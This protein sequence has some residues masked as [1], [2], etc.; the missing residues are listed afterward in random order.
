MDLRVKDGVKKRKPSCNEG[1]RGSNFAHPQG[2]L[3]SE[4]SVSSRESGSN[5]PKV[6]KQMTADFGL[7]GAPTN[8]AVRWQPVCIVKGRLTDPRLPG[9]VVRLRCLSGVR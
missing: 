5:Y 6:G 1:D 3:T 7:A 2:A 9:Q 8:Q 4:P